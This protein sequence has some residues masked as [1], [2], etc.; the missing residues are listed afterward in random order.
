MKLVRRLGLVYR[1]D[2]HISRAAQAFAEVVT[3]FQG[4]GNR[5]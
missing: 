1:T 3:A 2:R 5:E 4:T